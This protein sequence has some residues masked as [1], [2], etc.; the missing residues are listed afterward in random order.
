MILS[1]LRNPTSKTRMSSAMC[2]E[3]IFTH[4][5]FLARKGIADLRTR[6]IS[7][8][9][10]D[11]SGCAVPPIPPPPPSRRRSPHHPPPPRR[12]PQRPP[13]HPRPGP[14]R[15]QNPKDSS[16]PL[17]KTT[18]TMT[19]NQETGKR[20]G[21]AFPRGSC[22]TPPLHPPPPVENSG[23]LEAL[24][25]NTNYHPPIGANSM[26]GTINSN[27]NNNRIPQQVMG[28]IES[29]CQRKSSSASSV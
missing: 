9:F 1:S 20:R 11:A 5:A 17:E 3:Q 16:S 19:T 2:L 26:I 15:N 28:W 14:N 12:L 10:P 13:R 7:R 21:I 29:G 6:M 4:P 18:M 22:A 27:N 25:L 8:C 23:L 24:R